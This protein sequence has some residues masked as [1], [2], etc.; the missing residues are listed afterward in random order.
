MIEQLSNAI[1]FYGFYTKDKT[2]YTGL[3][4]TADVYLNGSTNLLFTG[5]SASEVGGGLYTYQLASSDTTTEGEYIT[6]FKTATTDADQQHIPALWVI[7]KAGIENLD[8]TITSRFAT[9]DTRADY[10]DGSILS[11]LA[12]SDYS[13][14][15]VSSSDIWGY[16]DRTLTGQS[17]IINVVSPVATGGNINI[18]AGDSYKTADGRQLTWSSTSWFDLTG[19][20]LA[21]S[22][23][24]VSLVPT[25]SGIYPAA[26]TL[27]LEMASSDTTAIK[28]GINYG[29][30][31]E[32]RITAA[33]SDAPPQ[34]RTLVLARVSVK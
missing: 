23:A 11:R 34:V 20:T 10:L 1:R 8:G 16:A 32:F 26:Q 3:T 12:S 15:N 30:A 18:I 29:S 19:Q 31:A 4:V 14:G 7:N 13:A 27:A 22:C 33:S 24:D 6:I 17:A 21:F 28:N 25:F 9:T 2:G 5:A